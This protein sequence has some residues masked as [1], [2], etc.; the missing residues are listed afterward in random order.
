M[1][2]WGV[3]HIATFLVRPVGTAN[4]TNHSIGDFFQDEDITFGGLPF[5][6]VRMEW[7]LPIADT[8]PI[9]WSKILLRGQ[10]EREG[11]EEL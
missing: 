5:L 1:V 2:A 3:L 4:G 9:N 6:P 7:R 11:H 10:M 8:Y